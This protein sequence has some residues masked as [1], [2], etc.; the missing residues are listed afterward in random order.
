MRLMPIS[1]AMFLIGE[2]RETPMH[3]GGINLYTLPDKVDETEW[4]NEQLAILRQQEGLRRPF[5]EV[6]KLTPLGQYGPIRLE[7]DRD[8]DMHYHVR[9]AALP[10]PG[11]YREMFELVSRLHGTLLDRT[12]PMWEMTL[13][14]GL[15]DRQVATYFK[16]HHALMDGAAS[17][18][19]SNSMLT[20][21]PKERRSHSPMSVEAYEAYKRLFPTPKRKS[22]LPS[23]TDLSAI[24][25]FLKQQWGNSVGVTKALNQYAAALFGIGGD[26]LTTPWA[27]VPRTSFNRNITGARRFVAQSWSL[28]RVRKLGKAYDGTIN[29]AVLGMCAGA[30]RKYLQSL[31][32]LPDKP[33]KAMA[34]VSIRSKDDVDSANSVAAVT[35]NLATHIDDPAERM[36]LIQESMNAAKAQLRAMTAQQIQIY[37]AITQMPAM[38]TALTRTADRFPAYSVTI[39]NVPGPREQLYWN[40]ARLDGI[41]PASIPVDGMAMNITQVSNN[42]NIDFGITACR[43][44]VPHAQ[45]MIDYLEEA[46]V[47]LEEAVG[48]KGK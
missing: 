5:G 13:I 17:Q 19:F 42:K 26:G 21:D 28:D 11:R 46:L 23:L 41:Y 34:P 47:E 37:T 20:T 14:S 39:S 33:L 27:G 44:S 7:P 30:M 24:G 22:P 16:I 12:R 31:N 6:L 43:R 10:K 18:H 1:D 36:R 38:L 32:E 2:T 35:A 40:G 29:D 9:A 8:I 4:L 25:D 45:R 48:I 15:P 3:I